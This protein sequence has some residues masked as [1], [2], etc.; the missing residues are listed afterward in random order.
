MKQKNSINLPYA[1]EN[2]CLAYE[3]ENDLY[4]VGSK[5]HVTLVDARS[6]KTCHRVASIV[7]GCGIRSLS[8][9]GNLMTVGTGVGTMF[10]FDIRAMNYICSVGS[11]SQLQSAVLK[12]RRT[13]VVSTKC[14]DLA[15][16]LQFF[17]FL[18]LVFSTLMSHFKIYLQI[19]SIILLPYILISMTLREQDCLPPVGRF[20]Q[21]YKEITLLCGVSSCIHLTFRK[22]YIKL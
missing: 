9:C 13:W 21:V 7:Q 18:S 8:F 2:V 11:K 14:F 5:S 16:I 20:Q 17:K 22:H 1:L 6:L 15:R 10:F 19:L 4:A 12:T 3:K